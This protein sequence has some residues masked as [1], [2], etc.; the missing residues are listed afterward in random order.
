MWSRGWI[1]SENGLQMNFTCNI[2]FKIDSYTSINQVCAKF[3]PEEASSIVTIKKLNLLSK[4]LQDNNTLQLSIFSKKTT[5][6]I[7]LLFS[8]ALNF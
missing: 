6:F 8:L 4:I 1:K 5:V 2:L 7:L 3:H